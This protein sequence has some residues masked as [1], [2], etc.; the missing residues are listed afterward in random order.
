M[1]D[2]LTRYQLHNHDGKQDLESKQ[3]TSIHLLATKAKVHNMTADDFHRVTVSHKWVTK[4]GD[5]T[6]LKKKST[7]HS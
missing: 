7:P 2:D 5:S 4:S 3:N 6:N 1:G